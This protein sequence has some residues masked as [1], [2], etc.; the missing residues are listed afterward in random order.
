MPLRP[1]GRSA[2]TCSMTYRL[3]ALALG[4]GCFSMTG[5]ASLSP[6]SR[7]RAGLMEAG[8][9]QRTASCMAKPMARDLSLVQLRRLQSLGGLRKSHRDGLTSAEL[10]H[11]LRALQDPDIIAVA[12]RAAIACAF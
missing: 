3:S 11:R 12:G 2:R 10:L 9:S 6:E 5:C 8:L 4:L 1:M 7:V